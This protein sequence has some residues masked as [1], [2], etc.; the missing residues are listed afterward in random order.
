MKDEELLGLIGHQVG[1]I[2]SGHMLYQDM[3]RILPTLGNLDRFR[4]TLGIGKLVTDAVEKGLLQWALMSDL[5]ADRAGLLTCQDIDK[6]LKLLMKTGGAPKKYFKKNIE[7]DVKGFKKQAREF[8]G[9]DDKS[10]EQLAKLAIIMEQYHPWA[11]LRASELLEWYEIGEYQRILDMDISTTRFC[12]NCESELTIDE[13]F[14]G[15]CGAK[16]EENNGTTILKR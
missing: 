8:K 13:I 15:D 6:Y 2:K 3:V 7:L 10:L 5:T 9:F 4:I 11:V 1:H 16:I 12:I 14:C